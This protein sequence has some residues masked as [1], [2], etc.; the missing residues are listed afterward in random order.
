[1]KGY[2]DHENYD[3]PTTIQI[4]LGWIIAMAILTLFVWAI[5]WV[6]TIGIALIILVRNF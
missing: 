3:E 2:S 1:M 6:L 5:G 4:L